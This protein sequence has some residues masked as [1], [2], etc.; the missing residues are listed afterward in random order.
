MADREWPLNE[1][2]R[3]TRSWR[4]CSPQKSRDGGVSY[5][6][7][8]FPIFRFASNKI[9]APGGGCV[10]QVSLLL[11]SVRNAVTEAFQ[12]LPRLV[13]TFAA[14]AVMIQMRAD[15]PLYSPVNKLLL[16]APALALDAISLFLPALSSADAAH[17]RARRV[18]VLRLLQVGDAKS[19]LG[20]AKSSR[21]VTLRA[22][23]VTL[24]ARWVTLRARWATLRARWATLRARWVMLRARWVTLRARWVTLRARWVTLRAR[25]ATLR[26]RWVTLRA[27][28]VTLRARWVTLRA[29]WVA[30]N[31]GR[32]WRGRWGRTTL[33]S[34]GASSCLTCCCRSQPAPWRM[35][36]RAST[37]WP[38][39]RCCPATAPWRGDSAMQQVANRDI[40]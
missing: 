30:P 24:R 12:Q 27:R 33:A 15:S 32:H 9:A 6:P 22:R 35:P 36:P 8:E 4:T 25:W 5:L 2:R 11:T 37:C 23:W 7:P 20:D 21:W 29:R 34:C 39:W 28:W 13:A 40:S 10:L 14:E 18:W 26:A 38:C 3:P 31:R 16:K 1:A 19:P 17:C